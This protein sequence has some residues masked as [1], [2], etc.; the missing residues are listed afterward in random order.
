MLDRRWPTSLRRNGR[1]GWAVL[2]LHCGRSCPAPAPGIILRPDLLDSTFLLGGTNMNASQ[3]LNRTVNLLAVTVVGLSAFA[4]L[5]ETIIENDLA[6]KVDDSLLFLLG[7]GA[8]AWYLWHDN[9]YSR[10]IIPIAL[11]VV[12]VLIKLYAV[13]VEFDDPESVGDDFGGIILFVLA[14]ALVI[15]EYARVPRLARELA[16]HG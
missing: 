5:P 12:A 7:I 9:R 13:S 2:G 11:V 6:D 8:I 10:T 4:F 15:Y 1:D 16:T 3:S 14:T